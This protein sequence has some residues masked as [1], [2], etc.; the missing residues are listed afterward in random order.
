MRL[1][2]WIVIVWIHLEVTSYL[3][4]DRTPLVKYYLARGKNNVCIYNMRKIGLYEYWPGRMV[5]RK[6]PT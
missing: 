6:A 2:F 4:G 1:A 5:E 3:A